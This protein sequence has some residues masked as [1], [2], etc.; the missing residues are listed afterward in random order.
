[1]NHAR[2]QVAP[3]TIMLSPSPHYGIGG[4]LLTRVVHCANRYGLF[5]AR[6]LMTQLGGEI[7]DEAEEIRSVLLQ[8]LKVHQIALIDVASEVTGKD[9][10][11]KIWQM[12]VSVPLAIAVLHKDMPVRTQCNIF[13]S[14]VKGDV[15][16]L[17]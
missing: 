6:S 7:P 8:V 3:D 10:L 11:H 2:K 5:F 13:Y 16:R 15:K 1:M 4:H 12:I 17:G 14:K 9:F